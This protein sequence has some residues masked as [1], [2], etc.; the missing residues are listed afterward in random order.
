[1]EGLKHGV[2]GEGEGGAQAQAWRRAGAAI[3]AAEET[4]KEGPAK[5]RLAQG[6]PG[7]GEAQGGEHR[8]G[9]GWPEGYEDPKYRE[10]KAKQ[11]SAC[12]EESKGHAT[13]LQPADFAPGTMGGMNSE[14]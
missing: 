8:K 2:D 11:A 5:K 12:P 1:M 3:P 13:L 14:G 6:G 4:L 9:R 10:K 7:G